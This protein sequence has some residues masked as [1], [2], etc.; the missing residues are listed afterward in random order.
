MTDSTTRRKAL[1]ERLLELAEPALEELSRQLL[2]PQLDADTKRELALQILKDSGVASPARA[3]PEETSSGLPLPA[4]SEA[5]TA[6]FQGLGLGIGLAKQLVAPSPPPS[7]SVERVLNQSTQI[8]ASPP[9]Q[10]LKAP[11]TRLIPG[12]KPRSQE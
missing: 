1:R 6:A 10:S 11:K 3:S 12:F 8:R 7:P 4:L 5:L 2:S 9:A